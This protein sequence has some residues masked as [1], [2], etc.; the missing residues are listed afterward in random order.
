VKTFGPHFDASLAF[1]ML[2]FFSGDLAEGVAA[3][4]EKRPPVFPHLKK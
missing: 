1:E 4:K 2:G 3:L